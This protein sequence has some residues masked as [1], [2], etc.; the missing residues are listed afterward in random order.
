MS[1]ILD[2]NALLWWLEDSPRFPTALMERINTEPDLWVSVVTP[3]EL[4]IKVS[5]GKLDLPG[6]LIDELRVRQIA[7][8]SPTLED[9]RLA[10]N[11]PLIHRD[12]F[13][14]MIVAQTFNRRATLI[15]SDRILGDYGVPVLLV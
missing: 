1:L 10:A 12:P 11:L 2:S 8:V 7:V 3:W 6:D 14:R 4:W 5:S 13:D 15:T 9:A